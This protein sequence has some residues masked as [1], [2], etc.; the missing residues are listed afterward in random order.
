MYG[1]R[2]ILTYTVTFYRQFMSLCV[3]TFR[4]SPP[5]ANQGADLFLITVAINL[6]TG[7]EVN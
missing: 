5:R 6:N 4:H 2:Y 7:L 1:C 3:H